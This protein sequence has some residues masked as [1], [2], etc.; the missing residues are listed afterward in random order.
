MHFCNIANSMLEPECIV[1]DMAITA[2]VVLGVQNVV[3]SAEYFQHI[4]LVSMTTYLKYDKQ[5]AW[6]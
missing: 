3:W 2:N 6:I 5:I 1:Y 4:F